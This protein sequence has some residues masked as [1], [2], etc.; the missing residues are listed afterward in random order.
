MNADA[1]IKFLETNIDHIEHMLIDLE[2]VLHYRTRAELVGRQDMA[3]EILNWIKEN[4][5]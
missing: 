4:S 3:E 5:D 1:L 2:D